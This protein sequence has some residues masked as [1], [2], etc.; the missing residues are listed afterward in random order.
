MK[1]SL[2]TT[3]TATLFAKS[4]VVSAF[5]PAALQQQRRYSAFEKQISGPLL[6]SIEVESEANETKNEETKLANDLYFP[7]SFKEMIKLCV[8][9][10]EDA[11]AQG[12]NR[13]MIRILL[14]RSAEN[15]QLLQ[16]YE[17]DA[18]DEIMGDTVLVP[19]DETWQG[20]SMQLYRGAYGK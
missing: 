13:H 19:P 2:I 7:S 1:F 11:Y 5:S 16:Y 10:M 9:S 14:P 3:V 18:K 8:S 20:G 12:I 17:D 4:N 6:M 15:D